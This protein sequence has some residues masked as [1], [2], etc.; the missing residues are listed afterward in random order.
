MNDRKPAR[1]YEVSAGCLSEQ[2]TASLAREFKTSR[3]RP[4]NRA[5][6]F[7]GTDKPTKKPPG[8][9]RAAQPNP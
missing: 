7:K 3:P 8:T 1:T 4:R 2:I 9:H 6:G 5:M